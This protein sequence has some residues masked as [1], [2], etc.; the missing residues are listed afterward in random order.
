MAHII[1]EITPLDMGHYGFTYHHCSECYH[2]LGEEE[3]QS[4][5]KCGVEF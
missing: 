3:P 2:N 5:P 1:I 4:C